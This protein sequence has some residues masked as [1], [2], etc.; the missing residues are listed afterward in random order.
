MSGA[1]RRTYLSDTNVLVHLIRASS[2]AVEI[3]ARYDL[4]E[5]LTRTLFSVVTVGELR[6]LAL[7]LG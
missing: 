2:L 3:D 1:E 6:S 5:E 4:R 7:Q